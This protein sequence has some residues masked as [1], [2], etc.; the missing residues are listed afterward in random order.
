MICIRLER[1]FELPIIPAPKRNSKLHLEM[2]TNP[3]LLSVFW[4]RGPACATLHEAL[5]SDTPVSSL[6]ARPRPW[7]PEIAFCCLLGADQVNCLL[8]ADQVNSLFRSAEPI[9][10]E[11]RSEPAHPRSD[12]AH[13]TPRTLGLTRAPACTQSDIE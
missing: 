3:F 2:W 4:A 10:L 12:P 1:F 7:E 9:P 13:P 5:T 8:G 6:G 11:T